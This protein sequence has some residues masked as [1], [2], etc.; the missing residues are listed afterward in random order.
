MPGWRTESIFVARSQ[1]NPDDRRAAR[2]PPAACIGARMHGTT[3]NQHAVDDHA[4]SARSNRAPS[5]IARSLPSA[6]SRGRYFMP[7]SGARMTFSFAT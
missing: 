3:G 6:T 1:H 4:N 7:Q 5:T 2:V